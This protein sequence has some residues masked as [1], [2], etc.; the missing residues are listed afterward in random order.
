MKSPEK[1]QP[2]KPAPSS[3]LGQMLVA[4]ALIE[5]GRENNEPS[6]VKAGKELRE[7]L[8]KS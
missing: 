8:E 3:N 1:K 5:A 2:T 6:M 4:K 7:I